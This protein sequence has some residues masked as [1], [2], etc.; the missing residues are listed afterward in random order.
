MFNKI[1]IEIP[2]GSDK[3]PTKETIEHAISFLP[4]N[5]T[6]NDIE[7]E[8]DCLAGYRVIVKAECR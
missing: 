1:R 8:N 5:A 4:E 2:F 6:I 7:I 3:G